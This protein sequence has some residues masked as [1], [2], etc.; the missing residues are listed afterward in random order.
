MVT[1]ITNLH[2]IK[3]FKGADED[4]DS[5]AETNFPGIVTCNGIIFMGKEHTTYSMEIYTPQ[6]LLRIWY[7]KLHQI[8]TQ[9]L[10]NF[11]H[12]KNQ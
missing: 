9:N 2:G 4:S 5:V 8:L 6:K 12:Q 11:G 7:S 1:M 10:V 3:N